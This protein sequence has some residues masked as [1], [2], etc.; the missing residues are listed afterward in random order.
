MV[1]TMLT[2]LGLIQELG[3]ATLMSQVANVF[4]SPCGKGT[5]VLMQIGA[6]AI[7]SAIGHN[8]ADTTKDLEEKILAMQ[9]KAV[10]LDVIGIIE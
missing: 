9:E 10:G 7:T 1:P 4:A 2:G 8:I 5:K 3:V 6:M